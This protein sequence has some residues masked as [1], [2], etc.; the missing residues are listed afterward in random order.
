MSL[1]LGGFFV[2]LA[3]IVICCGL[4]TIA[5][6]MCSYVEPLAAGSGIP[7]MKTYLNGKAVQVDIKLTPR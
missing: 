1:S 3:H 6:A 2:Y 4:A 7:E 5:G